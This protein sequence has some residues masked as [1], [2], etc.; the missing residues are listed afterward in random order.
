[1]YN[2]LGKGAGKF[3]INHAEVKVLVASAFKFLVLVQI[4][5]EISTVRCLLLT[6]DRLPASDFASPDDIARA[7]ARVPFRDAIRRSLM[8][9]SSLTP[10]FRSHGQTQVM[11]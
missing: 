8:I 1:V 4:A 2:S 9:W 10:K 7:I 11:R 6:S 3:R 5:D